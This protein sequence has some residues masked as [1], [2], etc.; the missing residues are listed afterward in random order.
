M[1]KH[2]VVKSDFWVD[3][4]FEEVSIKEKYFFLYLLTNPET[5]ILGIYKTTIKRMS[6][7]TG[8]TKTEIS[9]FL[10]TWSSLD[11]VY[12]KNSYILLVNH[13]KHN[14]PSGTMKKGIEK[15]ILNLPFEVIEFILSKKSIIYN[16]LSIGYL[17]SIHRANKDKD[18]N[19]G[20]SKGKDP[21]PEPPKPPKKETLKPENVSDQTWSDFLTHR[22]IKKTTTTQTVINTFS[23]QAK[24]AGMSLEEALIESI[25][26]GWVGFKAEWMN[27]ECG[28]QSQSNPK[29]VFKSE[30]ISEEQRQ[31]QLEINKQN[32]RRISE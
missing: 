11:K 24:L 19:K 30:V 27:K 22:K 26:R 13:H 3:D 20:K 5:N 10:G 31:K 25:S 28:T 16:R 32:S 29:Q 23:K 21:L 8:L 2:R 17:D 7:E 4:Y 14:I 1:S 6:F 15:L 9:E 12:F 18:I